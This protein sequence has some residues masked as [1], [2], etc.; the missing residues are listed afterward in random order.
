MKLLPGAGPR[1]MQWASS[2][3]G[4]KGLSE[5]VHLSKSRQLGFGGGFMY[6]HYYYYYYIMKDAINP[7]YCLLKSLGRDK[8]L[9][10][11]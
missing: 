8:P 2:L 1:N 7:Y 10:A 6:L 3:E 9:R 4:T 11:L 5:T